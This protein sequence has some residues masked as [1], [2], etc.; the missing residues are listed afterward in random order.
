MIKEIQ[1]VIKKLPPKKSLGPERHTGKFYKTFKELTLIVHNM[2]QKIEEEETPTN[3]FYKAAITLI[4]KVRPSTK[5]ETKNYR[6][7]S[8]IMGLIVP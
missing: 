7:I 4:T 3:S 8:L 5:K 6:P 2:F 1:F